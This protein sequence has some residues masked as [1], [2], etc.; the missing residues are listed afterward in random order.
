MSHKLLIE[1]HFG[2]DLSFVSSF[3]GKDASQE[4]SKKLESFVNDIRQDLLKSNQLTFPN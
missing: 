3:F 1:K 4:F 2:K